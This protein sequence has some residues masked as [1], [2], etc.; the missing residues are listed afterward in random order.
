MTYTTKPRRWAL[1]SAAVTILF[2]YLKR[3]FFS[4]KNGGLDDTLKSWKNSIFTCL[5]LIIA[6]SNPKKIS[7]FVH[8]FAQHAPR[9]RKKACEKGGKEWCVVDSDFSCVFI[10][11]CFF[12][13]IE[14]DVHTSEHQYVW[15][16][17]IIF[18]SAISG[19]NRSWS[20]VVSDFFTPE[21]SVVIP[22]LLMPG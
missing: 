9:Y 15:F 5:Y 1:P 21:L 20:R 4:Y 7:N 18:S 14:A 16:E 6:H 11:L 13:Y 2:M 19:F 10:L 8:G 17:A 12:I 22:N 3:M